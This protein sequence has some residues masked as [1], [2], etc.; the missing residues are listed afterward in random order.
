MLWVIKKLK[1]HIL[2][3]LLT[4][5]LLHASKPVEA[6]DPNEV[7]DA[8]VET[9]YNALTPNERVGQL[10]MVAFNGAGVSVESDIAELIQVYRVG[11]VMISAQNENFSNNQNTPA[12]VLA[13]TNNLQQLARQAPLASIEPGE[14]VTTT[15]T[16]AAAITTAVSISDTQGIYNPIPLFIAVNHEGDGFPETQIHSG[17]A[18]IP[19]PMAIG[20]TW[21]ME[22]A[23]RV[24][25]VVGYDL[26]LLGV[27]MLL[28]PSL[29]VLDN[30]RLDRGNSL[31]TRTFG[32]HPYWV[33]EMGYAYIQ[34]IHQGSGR[35]L[36]TI[37]KHFPGFGSSDREINQG[38][39]TI[40]K[41]LDDLRRGEL[42]PFFRVTQLTPD[43]TYTEG[44]TD[45][46][47][48]A[49]VRYQ[50]LQGTVSMSLD[51][52]NLP[53]ILALKEIAPWRD[54]GGLVVSA[55]LGAPAALEGIAAGQDNFPARRLAQDAFLAGSDILLLGDFAFAGQAETQLVNIKNAIGFFQEKYL[56]D[57]NFQAAVDR[58]VRRIIKA[59]VRLYGAD[60]FATQVQQ[61]EDNLAALGKVPLDLDQIA[62]AGVTLITPNT[63][64]E[65][66]PLANPPQPGEDV[67][68]F[69][70]DRL[71]R[72]CSS[73]PE[74]RLIET[75]AL[76]EIILQS[77]GPNA[78]GQI[79]PEQLNS[80][81]F[82]DLK[83]WVSGSSAEN[84][85]VD[86]LI[87]NADWIIFAMLNITPETVP[88]SDA[89]RVLLRTRF[90]ALR[91]KKLVVFAF[92]APYFLDETEISQLTAYYAFYSK[93]RDYLE[94]AA[95]LLFQQ[96]K[97]SGASPVTIP[98]IGPLNLNP[99]PNQIIELQPVHKINKDGTTVP[100]DQLSETGASI[101]LAVGE[102]ILFRTGI[103][104]D[105]NG[106][107]VPDET[108]VEFFRYYPL[109][110]LPLEPLQSKTV[111]GVAEINII[112]ERDSPL[113]VRA[114]SNLA[115]QSIP[116]DIGPGIIDTPTPTTT[117]TPMPTDTPTTTPTASATATPV[118]VTATPTEVIAP[119]VTPLPPEA[120]VP[121]KP[122]EMVDL[123][124]SL[125][126]AILIG[127]IAFTLG[128]ERF[129]LEQR[130]RST[131]VAIAAG[132]VGYIL[133]TIVA[134]SFSQTEYMNSIVRQSAAGHW[135]APLVT[136]LFAVIGV[137][138]WHL[139]PGRSF[140]GLW[141]D[142]ADRIRWRGNLA[143]LSRLSRN[144][145]KNDG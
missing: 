125:L 31:G 94:A 23:R 13:L 66:N 110:G 139:K 41:S 127:G 57:T 51:A 123:I 107:P 75:T 99:D 143:I 91:N 17:L 68:I 8:A 60:L 33:G 11:G 103:I 9:I 113:Q 89:V 20:A 129:P 27:N 83:N 120:L 45:G 46:L 104:M 131:L 85:D 132:L 80:R 101:D 47:M 14:E 25:E 116:F 90:D 124:Y 142:F 86:T 105:R 122:V 67:L 118:I 81:G 100:L 5:I 121:P 10:F 136:V 73:C 38:V 114:S 34:G 18:E 76:Q 95:R 1:F 37:A 130:V 79:S 24:G 108:L 72:D 44:T 77:F 140:N 43:N 48:T 32:G 115:A 82:T 6:Q 96:F 52:R 15:L 29:D 78:T 84:A 40:L 92:N 62:H 87:Q 64:E 16:A 144:N 12:Q 88:Q 141:I 106:H 21:Q 49:H 138:A 98:A 58:A 69:T 30:P 19:S 3:F 61:P 109:E 128:G 50:G 117:F 2:L 112:K 59:K 134:M 36:L 137:L 26:S 119:T 53:T 55:P 126:G 74:F 22:N 54:A 28:G 111:N 97:P 42:R 102:G 35:R 65:P 145:R 56:T 71:A 7:I 4:F 70:D 63:Q 39:P 133:F 135:V 93:T